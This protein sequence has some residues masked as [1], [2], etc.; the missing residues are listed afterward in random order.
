M[1]C[2]FLNAVVVANP[3]FSHHAFEAARDAGTPYDVP[4]QVTVEAGFIIEDPQA[5]IHCCPGDSNADPIAEPVDDECREAVRVWMTEKR[6]A[7]IAAIKA[8]LD[9]IDLIQDEGHRNRLKQ[10][11]RAYGLLPSGDSKSAGKLKASVSDAVK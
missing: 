10:L 3:T 7:G 2:R 11:G 8:Q 4:R 9:Q 1:K 6:P 5:W